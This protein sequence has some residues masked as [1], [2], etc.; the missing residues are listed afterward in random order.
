MH[1]PAIFVWVVLLVPALAQ[2][3]PDRPRRDQPG[4]AKAKAAPA[5][6]A[7]RKEDAVTAKDKAVAALD[8]FAAASKVSKKREDWR[9]V[10]PEPPKQAFT[11]GC[12][13]FWKLQTNLGEITA[14]L[15]PDVAPMHVTSVVYLTR[16]GFY[17]GLTFHRAIK[18]FMAQGGCPRGDGMGNAGYKMEGEFD[19]ATKHDRAGLLSAAN[20]G[21]PKTDGSQFFITFAPAPHLDGKHTIFGEVTGGQDVVQA[22]EARSGE[23]GSDKPTADLRIE[24]ASIQV[25]ALPKA[26]K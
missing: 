5:A 9:Q 16:L 21:R 25:V 17:D 7:E 26:D 11:P 20:E 24:R 15:R 2:T 23:D 12:D 8:K 6:K 18:G 3:K 1:A 14:R 13:Y 19:A 22:L 4:A 10:L